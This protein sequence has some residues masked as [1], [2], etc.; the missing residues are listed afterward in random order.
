MD[1]ELDESE[2][3]FEVIVSFIGNVEDLL[4]LKYEII[5]TE[6]QANKNQPSEEPEPKKVKKDTIKEIEDIPIFK[7]TKVNKD[8][9]KVKL[10]KQSNEKRSSTL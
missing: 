7:N 9:L 1:Q 4:E 5:T 3:L 8:F 6:R 2:T 10:K